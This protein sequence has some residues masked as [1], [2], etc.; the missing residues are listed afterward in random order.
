MVD[1]PE[2]RCRVG[3]DA[4]DV[5]DVDGP[6]PHGPEPAQLTAVCELQTHGEHEPSQYTTHASTAMPSRRPTQLMAGSG[7]TSP[8][9]A[10]T[11]RNAGAP[12]STATVTRR[13]HSPNR[14]PLGALATT[15]PGPLIPGSR[16]GAED[17]RS[18]RDD[19][20]EQTQVAP[21]ERR[22]AKTQ[23]RSRLSSTGMWRSPRPDRSPETRALHRGGDIVLVGPPADSAD[24]R[25]STVPT[26]AS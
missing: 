8:V 20:A 25:F 9:A 14:L 18:H 4:I 11:S 3:G 1:G 2:E 16:R 22:R 6:L 26:T 19:R 12:A 7:S 15:S 23:P 10:A 5:A 21:R 24:A 17:P 13:F